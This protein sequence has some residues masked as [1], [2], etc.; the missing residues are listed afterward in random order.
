MSVA[1]L[2]FELGMAVSEYNSGRIDTY[3]TI[4]QYTLLYLQEVK[5]GISTRNIREEELAEYYLVIG[6]A[7]A[8]IR[9]KEEN[10]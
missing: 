4:I 5:K 9:Q 7:W 8:S 3:D 6:Q 10:K 2:G 1:Q